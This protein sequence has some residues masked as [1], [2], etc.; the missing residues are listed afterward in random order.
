MKRKGIFS[1]A[2]SALPRGANS[3]G[4]IHNGNEGW[5][6]SSVWFT[7]LCDS[8]SSELARG[9]W[10]MGGIG[11]SGVTRESALLQDKPCKN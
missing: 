2:S 7:L 4:V 6:G 8:R 3:Q 11:G 10:W 1:S 9:W 5:W